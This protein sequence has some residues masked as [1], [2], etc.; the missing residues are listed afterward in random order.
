MTAGNKLS[1]GIKTAQSRTTYEDMLR[2][3][4][5]ADSISSIEHAWMFDHFMPLRPDFGDPCLEGWM[6]L[7]AFAAIT[8]RLRL[9]LTV[10]SNTFRHPAVLAKMAA[11]IDVVSGG[12]LDFGI[13]AG[14][15]AAEHAAYGF[16]FY[17][18]SERLDRLE[19]SCE[20]IRRMWTE[21]APS[22][23]GQYYQIQ[24]AYCEPRPVQRPHPPFMI[25]GVGEHLLRIAARYAAIWNY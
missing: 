7:A 22:F 23:A 6:L 9:G 17:T 2:V 13:G 12:R 20:L 4:R 1:F 16:P 25:G 11:T 14:I 5:E 15:Y 24:D 19:E 18:H 3:W 21:P 10:T 8:K